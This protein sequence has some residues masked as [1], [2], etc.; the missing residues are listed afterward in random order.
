ML[1]SGGCA[2]VAALTPRGT[3]TST[4]CKE[5]ELAVVVLVIIGGDCQHAKCGMRRSLLPVAQGVV[6]AWCQQV[7]W[8]DAK[9]MA[10]CHI[11]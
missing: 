7:C 9:V 11:R 2:V 4:L 8:C 10:M 6:A 5:S 3:A 1:R